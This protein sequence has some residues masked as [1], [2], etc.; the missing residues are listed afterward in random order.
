MR[1]QIGMDGGSYRLRLMVVVGEV[2]TGVEPARGIYISK[3]APLL[4]SATR[5]LSKIL[6]GFWH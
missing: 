6:F 1:K 5:P 4:R 2:L 3:P